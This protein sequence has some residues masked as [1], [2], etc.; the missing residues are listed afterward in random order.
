MPEPEIFFDNLNGLFHLQEPFP[1]RSRGLADFMLKWKLS[2]PERNVG[3][4][5]LTL[6]VTSRCN[7]RCAY[8]WQHSLSPLDMRPELAERTTV[9]FLG[10]PDGRGVKKITFYGGEPLLNIRAIFS[11]CRAVERWAEQTGNEPPNLHVFTNGTLI[12]NMALE[13]F[14][15][16]RV[17]PIISVDGSPNVTRKNRQLQGSADAWEPLWLSIV[18]L[19]DAGLKFGIACTIDDPCFDVSSVAA[20]LLDECR[21]ETIEFNL[22][23]D[24]RFAKQVDEGTAPD[25]VPFGRAWDLCCEK[26]VYAIDLMKRANALVSGTPLWNS[27]SGCKNKIAV[28][29][30]G[31]VSPFNGAIAAPELCFEEDSEEATEFFSWLWSREVRQSPE[32]DACEALFLCGQGSAFSSYLQYGVLDRVPAL[33][34]EY[35]RFVVEYFKEAVKR[36]VKTGNVYNNGNTLFNV[37]RHG[38]VEGA[39]SITAKDERKRSSFF[40][41]LESNE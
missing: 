10:G 4:K 15:R 12:D 16:F 39:Y 1:G 24:A 37:A 23:H 14:E 25:F 32:C 34:C 18:R 28:M 36:Y 13:V 35:A 2:V 29:P 33:H 19:Q 26:G 6:V 27:S 30:D 9:R 17:Y 31:S 22:R 5:N 11:S 40:R 8:C 41:Q 20:F 38:D 3:F 7:M 21:P